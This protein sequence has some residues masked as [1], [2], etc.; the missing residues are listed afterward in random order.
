M[1]KSELIRIIKEEISSIL[2]EKTAEEI[3]NDSDTVNAQL[4]AAKA[5]LKSATA[6][7]KVAKE[8]IV[9]LTRKKSE[10]ASQKPTD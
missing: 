7:V 2:L 6:E 5:K 8:Q 1:K 4:L 10:V 3:K 9:A